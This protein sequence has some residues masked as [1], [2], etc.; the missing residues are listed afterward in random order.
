MKKNLKQFSAHDEMERNHDLKELLSQLQCMSCESHLEKNPALSGVEI[1][2]K[3]CTCRQDEY[4]S[5]TRHFREFK[6]MKEVNEEI[7]GLP[8]I[9]AG[10]VL[11]TRT[12]ERCMK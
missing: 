10:G 6:A 2:I 3:T 12:E 7:G 1:L 8:G 5:L 11:F 4:Q 9:R